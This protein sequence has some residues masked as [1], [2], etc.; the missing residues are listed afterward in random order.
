M[1]MELKHDAASANLHLCSYT[2]SQQGAGSA[3]PPESRPMQTFALSRAQRT[4]SVYNLRACGASVK[5]WRPVT[6][7]T[8][9]D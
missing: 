7:Q 3:R 4:E 8:L 2:G 1:L 9:S 5:P 6:Q